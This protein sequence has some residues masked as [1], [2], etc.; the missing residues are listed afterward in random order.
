[1][2]RAGDRAGRTEACERHL[3]PALLMT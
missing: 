1:V 3:G 2:L